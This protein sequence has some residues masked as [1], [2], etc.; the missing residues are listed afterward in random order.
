MDSLTFLQQ[1]DKARPQPVFVL[2]GDEEFLKRQCSLAIRSVVLG[3][4]DDGF[5]LSSYPGDKATW[6]QVIEDLQTLPF[7]G[8]RR[9][10]I[11]ESADPFVSRERQ[12][13]EKYFAEV[14]EKPDASGILVLDVQ[15]WTA[16]TK[17]AKMTPDAWLLTCKP[18][19]S[20]HLPQWCMQWCEKSHGKKLAPAAAR[21]LVDHVG[22]EMGLLDSEMEKLAVY[23]GNNPQIDARDVDQLVGQSRSENTW[24]IFDLIGSGAVGEALS[25][26]QRLID[27]GEDPLRLLGAFSMQMRRLAQASRLKS[28]G[29]SLQE[30]MNRAGIP[31]FPMAR[32]AAEK[33]MRH[34]GM[35]RLDR[36]YDWLL[37]VDLGMKGGSQLPPATLLERLVIR[38]ARSRPGQEAIKK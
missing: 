38:L 37:E 15:S 25:F 36:L 28:Q 13:L 27:Q 26:L 19:A 35:S 1:R 16:T 31:N 22:S 5:G 34:L 12:R 11:I 24:Q 2:H 10:V 32:Q 9:L 14:K 29:V 30:S 7:F 6:S 33:Q 18:P 23:A 3:P 4:E 8:P 20:Q 17:L 21:L